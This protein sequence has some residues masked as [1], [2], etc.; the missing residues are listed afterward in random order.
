MKITYKFNNGD[1][2]E[3]DVAEEIGAVIIESRRTEESG[4]RKAR[5]HNYS[6]NAI[7]YEGAEFAFPDFTEEMFDD[8]KDCAARVREAFSHLSKV[9]Q[10]RLLML[11]AGLSIREIS[12]REG[13]NFST[14][15]ESIE[16]ARKKFLK[17]FE[18]YPIK[19]S[20]FCPYGER[21]KKQTL[22]KEDAI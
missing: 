11:A 22:G 12:R 9:Q 17:F 2:A 6:L 7:L 1:T 15:Y 20:S 5:R 13:K 10:Q 18:K 19:T 14:V 4:E 3:V 8:G 16:A 21:R